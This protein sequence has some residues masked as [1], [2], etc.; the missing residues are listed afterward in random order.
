MEILPGYTLAAFWLFTVISIISG[1]YYSKKTPAP[2]FLFLAIVFFAATIVLLSASQGSHSYNSIYFQVNIDQR[3]P[4]CSDCQNM[5]RRIRVIFAKEAGRSDRNKV[6]YSQEENEL[7]EQ[8]RILLNETDTEIPLTNET[9]VNPHKFKWIIV[10]K[11]LCT[12]SRR[13]FILIIVH[14]APKNLKQRMF[15]RETWG[16]AEISQRLNTLIVFALGAFQGPLAIRQQKAVLRENSVYGDIIQEDFVDNYRNLT[17]K[18]VMWLRWVTYYCSEAQY[19]LKLDDDIFTNMFNLV[20]H[21]KNLHKRNIA[22]HNTLACN[23]WNGVRVDRNT[24]SKW[25][26]PK[27]EFAASVYPTYCS[28]SAYLMSADLAPKLYHASFEVPFFWVDDFWLTGQV[29]AHVNASWYQMR[30]MF[31]LI[32][33]NKFIYEESFTDDY[34]VF[35]HVPHLKMKDKYR[36]WKRIAATYGF[37]PDHKGLL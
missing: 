23:V 33:K 7:S 4:E 24:S 14:S 31:S 10:E 15:I 8:E 34:V 30:S 35:G 5:D 9:A 22:R 3:Q 19:V 20:R 11:N 12:S 6:A 37:I 26:V 27:T 18:T 25:F 29:A 32:V 28:G 2:F 1:L 16:A 17:Y 13:P 36:V 21:V